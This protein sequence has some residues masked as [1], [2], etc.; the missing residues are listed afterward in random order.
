METRRLVKS[1]VKNDFLLKRTIIALYILLGAAT[2]A[3]K[4]FDIVPMNID[5][6]GVVASGAN[7]IA[8]GNFG[9]YL[10]TTDKGKTWEQYSLKDEFGRILEI[11]DYRDTLWGLIS[12]IHKVGNI[13]YII[14]SLDN[15]YTWN[16]YKIIVLEEN[17]FF[18]DLE[19]TDNSI[20]IKSRNSVYKLNR[21]FEIERSFTDTLT[22]GTGNF[23]KYINNQLVLEA[24]KGYGEKN[25]EQGFVILTKD[26]DDMKFIN[27]IDKFYRSDSISGYRLNEILFLNEEPVYNVGGHLYYSNEDFSEW[28]YF[29]A[30]TSFRNLNNR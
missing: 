4:E 27:L 1:R 21:N 6:S 18:R 23:L 29:F 24:D 17:D 11:V 13:G 19:L 16:K 22:Q 7:V 30:D 3:A 28:T 26:L 8:Y 10:M 25:I 20:Y 12:G 9:A 2:L 15:G 14:Q 5:F